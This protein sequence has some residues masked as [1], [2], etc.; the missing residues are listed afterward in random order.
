MTHITASVE[1]ERPASEVFG[2]LADME[3]N[4]R[5]QK[6]QEHCQWTSEP[7]LRLGS[8][9]DQEAKFLGKTITSS[10]E[11]VEFVPGSTIRIATTS[12]TMPIDVTREVRPLTDTSCEVSAVVRGDAPF[13]MRLLGPLLDRIVRSSVTGDYARLKTLLEA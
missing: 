7:P 6:G 8:T 2:Y 12:G 10:F 5:W 3:N 11:V 4:P 9:Y 1:I 13:P